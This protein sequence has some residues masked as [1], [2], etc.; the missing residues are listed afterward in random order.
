[1][2]E[3]VQEPTA[4]QAELDGGILEAHPLPTIPATAA[5]ADTDA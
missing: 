5:A 4:A 3:P 2:P 1:M